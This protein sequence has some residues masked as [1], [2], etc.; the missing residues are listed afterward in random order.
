MQPDVE[1]KWIL[2]ESGPRLIKKMRIDLKKTNEMKT[3]DFEFGEI[4]CR[5][6]KEGLTKLGLE[7]FKGEKEVKSR[8]R[9]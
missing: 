5:E 1:A 6:V 8:F 9:V 3:S 4:A 7:F 2:G